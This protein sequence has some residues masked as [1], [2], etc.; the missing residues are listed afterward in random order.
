M[1]ATIPQPAMTPQQGSDFAELFRQVKAAGL[2]GRRP[3]YYAVKITLTALAFVGGWVAFALLGDSWWQLAVAAFLGIVFTQMGFLGHDAGHRQIFR[4][5]WANDL[6]GL[7]H[8]NL[9]IGLSFGWW[10][11]KHNAHHGQ[12]NRIGKDPD[13]GAGAVLF[14]SDQARGRQGVLSRFVGRYQAFLFFPMLLLEGLNLHVSSIQA[15]K[16]RPAKNRPWE[17]ALLLL[18]LGGYLTAVFLVLSPGQAVAFIAVQQG[19]F[20]LYMGLSFAPNHKGMP[21]LAADEKLDFL[22]TQVLTAR[23]VRGG[24]VTDFALGGLNYQIEHHLFPSMPR[25][26]LRRVQPMVA[27]FCARKSVLYT[28]TSLIDSYRQALGHLHRVGEPLRT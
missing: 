2:L 12:P 20:G 19:L 7:L 28:E 23:N 11:A 18:H 5:R 8:G 3:G 14:T 16:A 6:T 4:S 25:P 10:V 1:T 13:I 9:L 15:L 22:H 17:A 21:M 24:R 26:N 27:E